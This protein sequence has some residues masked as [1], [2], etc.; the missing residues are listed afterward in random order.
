LIILIML[1]EEYRLWSSPLSSLSTLLL[2]H[3]SFVQIFTNTN[4]VAWVRVQTV[5]T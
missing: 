1:G 5:P 4:S 3:I 2:L